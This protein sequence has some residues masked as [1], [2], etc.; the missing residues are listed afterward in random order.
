MRVVLARLDK[1][2]KRR[3]SG[4]EGFCLRATGR[5]VVFSAL[6]RNSKLFSDVQFFEII[7][8]FLEISNTFG[9]DLNLKTALRNNFSDRLRSL[10]SPLECQEKIS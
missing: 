7:V 10:N 6:Q 5:L 1:L 3:S 8:F 2:D 4:F 9:S